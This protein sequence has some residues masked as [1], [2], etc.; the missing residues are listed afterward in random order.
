MFQSVE[1]AAQLFPVSFSG[2]N[3]IREALDL[4]PA[5]GGLDVEGFDVVAEVGVDVLVIISLW[6][7]SKLPLETL[8]TS[9]VLSGWAPTV[10]APIAEG[11]RVGFERGSANDIH[12]SAFTHGEVVRWVE[13]LGGDVAE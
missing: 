8:A 3:K 5:D 11:F 10:A 7:F 2:L 12:G 13:R 9:V 6:K 1:T 4:H